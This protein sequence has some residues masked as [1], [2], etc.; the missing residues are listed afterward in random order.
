MDA[1]KKPSRRKVDYY[2][3]NSNSKY[4]NDRMCIKKYAGNKKWEG[5]SL[6]V[7]AAMTCNFFLKRDI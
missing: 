7:A 5:G 6:S 3:R 1:N 2:E 4:G